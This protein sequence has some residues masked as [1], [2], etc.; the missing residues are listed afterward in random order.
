MASVVNGV[1]APRSISIA[2]CGRSAPSEF[3]VLLFV[4]RSSGFALGGVW[5]VV[6]REQAA[7]VYI[8]GRG[9]R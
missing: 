5:S 2:D 8:E 4:R 7:T 3:A 6:Y 9:V 1:R